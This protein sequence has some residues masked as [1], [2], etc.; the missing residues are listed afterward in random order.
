MIR[1]RSNMRHATPTISGGLAD[2]LEMM[3][4]SIAYAPDAEIYGAN[5]A[6][7]YIHKLV[8]GTVRTTK[9]LNSYCRQVGEFYLPGDI[10][11]LEAGSLHSFSAEAI[12]VTKIVVVKRTLVEARAASDNDFA[13]QL[14]ATTA[15][16]LKRAQMHVLLL[17]QS[18]EQ[19]VA[20]FLLEMCDRFEADEVELAMGRRDIADYLGLTVET[21]SRMLSTLEDREAIVVANPRHIVLRNRAALLKLPETSAIEFGNRRGAKRSVYRVARRNN[22]SENEQHLI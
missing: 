16:E 7:E 19:R 12:T 17:N 6:A 4:A 21:V 9:I 13:R 18:A 5:E 15:L 2:A 14:W 8:S 22:I 10:F 11:G 20:S 1:I 3:G